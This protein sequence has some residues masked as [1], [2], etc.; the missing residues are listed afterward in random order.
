MGRAFTENALLA[1][2]KAFQQRTDW[3][4]RRPAV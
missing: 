3:H 2:G 4:K 1:V